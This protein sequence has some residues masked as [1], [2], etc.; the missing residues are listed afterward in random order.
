MSK[1]WLYLSNGIM[2]RSHIRFQQ[3]WRVL[4]IH[5][6]F[7]KSTPAIKRRLQDLSELSSS[8]ISHGGLAGALI[9][10][11]EPIIVA[12]STRR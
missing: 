9:F 10:L 7:T 5:P 1:G 4:T 2:K 6:C 12:T 3:I 11:N 8:S